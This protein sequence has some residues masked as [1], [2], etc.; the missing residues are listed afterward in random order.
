MLALILIIIFSVDLKYGIGSKLIKYADYFILSRGDY[1]LEPHYRN[2]QGPWQIKQ[3][4]YKW[5]EV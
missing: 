1:W 5:D 3:G 4:D 2:S